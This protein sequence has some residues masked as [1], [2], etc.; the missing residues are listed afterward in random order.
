MISPRITT[1]L[2]LAAGVLSLAAITL[3]GCTVEAQP[4]RPV[5]LAP[6]PAGPSQPRRRR[7]GPK[8]C[9]RRPPPPMSGSRATGIGMA[10]AM[11]G[12][13]AIMWC[14]RSAGSIGCMGIGRCAA[15]PGYGCR[16]IGAEAQRSLA[17]KGLARAG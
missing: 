12:C 4:A 14:A 2:T 6:G 13:A 10:Y 9:R 11:S 15:G 17:E 7:C 1:R 5:V 16:R 3:A 8:P